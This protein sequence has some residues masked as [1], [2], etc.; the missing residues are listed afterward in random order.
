MQAVRRYWGGGGEDSQSS[1]LWVRAELWVSRAVPWGTGGVGRPFLGTSHWPLSPLAPIASPSP[2]APCCSGSA[3]QAW[4]LAVQHHP[5][6]LG[7]QPQLCSP[8]SR[9]PMTAFI[10]K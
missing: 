7:T 10:G 1:G 5:G 9:P 6:V 2:S 8:R 4:W 3:A